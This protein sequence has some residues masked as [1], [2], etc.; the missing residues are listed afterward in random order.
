MNA[1]LECLKVII[2]IFVST[3]ESKPGVNCENHRVPGVNLHRPTEG[4]RERAYA[5]ELV[6]RASTST[7]V[8]QVEVESKV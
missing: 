4:V 5:L 7:V 1:K 6:R 2:P 8:A 3:I